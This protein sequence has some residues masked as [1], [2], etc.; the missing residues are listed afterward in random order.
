MPITLTDA[1]IYDNHLDLTGESNE[2]TLDAEAAVKNAECFGSA[3]EELVIGKRKVDLAAKGRLQTVMSSATNSHDFTAF[4]QQFFGP[5][6]ETFTVGISQT[7]DTPAYMLQAK[8]GKYAIYG[9]HGEVAPWEITAMGDGKLT[10]GRLAKERGNVSATGA[11]GS[12]LL[13]GAVSA[14]QYL[15]A[16]FHVFSAGTTITVVVESDD[17]VN[18]TSATTRATIGPLTAAGGTYVTPV[19]G[20]ITDTYYRLRVTAITGTFNVAGAIGVGS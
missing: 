15:Y 7:E 3:W 19:A 11:L 6:A 1:F 17:N 12:G 10:R 9:E 13:L 14:S 20:A 2:V 5:L 18:F 16:T 8:R 4:F